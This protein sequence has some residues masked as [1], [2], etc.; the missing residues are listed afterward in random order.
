MKSKNKKEQLKKPTLGLTINRNQ[1]FII[2]NI[3]EQR[4]S[5][6]NINNHLCRNINLNKL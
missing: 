5:R 3:G 1:A 4:G 6:D 2:N